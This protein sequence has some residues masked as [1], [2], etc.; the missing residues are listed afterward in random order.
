MK[1]KILDKIIDIKFIY[2]L[3][4][5][6]LII[7]LLI[8]FGP[9]MDV[10]LRMETSKYEDIKDEKYYKKLN[11]KHG[12]VAYQKGIDI[13]Y[14]TETLFK[15]TE[16]VYQ[17]GNDFCVVKMK[18]TNNS[19]GY[20]M[21]IG[22]NKILSY[23]ARI[24][25]RTRFYACDDYFC[26][27]AQI[28]IYNA[29]TEKVEKTVDVVSEVKRVL[30]GNGDFQS[31]IV[32]NENYNALSKEDK[33]AIFV[34]RTFANPIIGADKSG[35]RIMVF[36]VPKQQDGKTIDTFEYLAYYIDEGQMKKIS[37]EDLPDRIKEKE[38]KFDNNGQILSGLKTETDERNSYCLKN[39]MDRSAFETLLDSNKIKYRASYLSDVA[40]TPVHIKMLGSDLDKRSKLAKKFPELVKKYASE[41]YIIDWYAGDEKNSDEIAKQLLPEGKKLNYDTVHVG[42]D[43]AKNLKNASVDSL[44]DYY[45]KVKP[46]CILEGKH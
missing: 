27:K 4:F 44:K 1:K 13:D 46:Q 19:Y 15:N 3:V 28:Q 9:S 22:D 33:D 10:I 32:K 29:D 39:Y 23:D 38:I 35:K 40:K 34:G 7:G 24:F 5:I 21:Q 42:D 12:K 2:F 17:N 41:D 26:P 6:F 37:F 16:S 43:C 30:G 31:N 8:K 25:R 11:I 45:K 14:S 18:G 36:E 20:D